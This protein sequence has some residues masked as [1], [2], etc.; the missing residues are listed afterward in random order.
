MV[1]GHFA[2]FFFKNNALLQNAK[3]L[4]IIKMCNIYD[5]NIV[6]IIFYYSW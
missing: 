5:K 1:L 6:F 2:E 3:N 4:I